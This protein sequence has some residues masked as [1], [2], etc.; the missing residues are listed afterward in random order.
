M[1]NMLPTTPAIMTATV[2]QLIIAI[3]VECCPLAL[4][5]NGKEAATKA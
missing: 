2:V 3:V 4:R 1:G 5:A